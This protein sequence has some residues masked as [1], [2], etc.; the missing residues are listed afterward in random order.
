M[1]A[2]L[3]D[4]HEHLIEEKERLQGAAN[5]RVPCDDWA[6][7]F[8]HYLNSDL[9]NSGMPAEA[10]KRFLS[11]EVDPLE[12]WE[13]LE[14]YWPAV[15]NTGY[16][17]AVR[18]AIR[19][20]Y[21]VEEL[22]GA[23]VARV[24]EGYDKLR[25]P[26]FYRRVLNELA[27]IASCQVNC[28]TGEAFKESDMPTLLMQDISIVG[29]F[30][31]PNFRQ[32][33]P[34]T[35]IEVKSLADWH[36]VIRWWFDHYAQY[37]VAVKSQNA[38]SR[39]IDYERIPA[40]QAEPVFNKVLQGEPL[41]PP[42]RK[43]LEDHLFWEAVDQATA[44]QLPVKL[45]TGF[46]AGQNSMPLERLARNPGS[47]TDLCR[48]SPDTRFVFMHIGYPYYE[49]MIAV[50]K[51]WTNAHLDMCWSWIINPI[52]AKDFLKKFLV[53]APAN[54][55]LPFGADYIPVEPVL[56]HAIM[57]RRGVA[58]A[59]TELVTEGWLSLSDALEL[60]DPVLHGNARQ[61]FDLES[62]TRV[63]AK[64]PWGSA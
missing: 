22:S 39:D 47:A 19:E 24:Q 1:A 8:S 51:Q 48:R 61:L 6:L 49:E 45:H 9:L 63:L 58:Q 44:C 60:V 16:A 52:A 43:R 15:K 33:A 18:I 59:L 30:A 54:K 17:Q 36:R 7:L 13:I 12:K 31:G 42:E 26:G 5:P 10:H 4:T 64:A 25:R 29:M 27:N 11:A 55:V 20:L 37:A 50:A 40:E 46:Y 32:Y 2:P 35:G 53:T 56:G 41:S 14:P 3:I 23:T 34:K 38:Y 21:G 57:A 62:K 28:L